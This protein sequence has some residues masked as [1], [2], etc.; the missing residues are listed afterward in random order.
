MITDIYE[1]LDKYG[2]DG[3]DFVPLFWE[4]YKLNNQP[5]YKSYTKEEFKKETCIIK[6]NYYFWKMVDGKKE[7]ND[8]NG[9]KYEIHN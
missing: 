2:M 6:S 8:W 9:K 5:I 3:I 4:P 1:D 7:Y